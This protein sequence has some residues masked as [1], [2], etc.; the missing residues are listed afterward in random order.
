M[1][2]S[3]TVDFSVQV[4]NRQYRWYFWAVLCELHE[5]VALTLWPWHRVAWQIIADVLWRQYSH[6]CLWCCSL[7]LPAALCVCVCVWGVCVTQLMFMLC[8]FDLWS[9]IFNWCIVAVEILL[10]FMRSHLRSNEHHNDSCF[11]LE[12]WSFMSWSQTDTT[13]LACLE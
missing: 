12:F 5:P 7:E 2:L 8:D 4:L 6:K 10:V 13:G 11:A 9:C 1:T 3:F